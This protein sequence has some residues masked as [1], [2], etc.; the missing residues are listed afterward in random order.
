MDFES[1]FIRKDMSF[2][3]TEANSGQRG[4]CSALPPPPSEFVGK[5]KKMYFKKG[6]RRGKIGEKRGGKLAKFLPYS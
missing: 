6:K 3:Y 2:Y 4:H 5:C 1:V